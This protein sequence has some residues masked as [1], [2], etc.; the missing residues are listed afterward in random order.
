V[1]AI[2]TGR[3]CKVTDAEKM[4][5]NIRNLIKAV[6]GEKVADRIQILYGGSINEETIQN[7]AKSKKINGF[8]VG[9]ASVDD[10]KFATI[11]KT[12]EANPAPEKPV[13]KVVKQ[14]VKK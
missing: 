1:W 4:I 11:V 5:D 12:V 9:S 2:G 10:K 7:F 3:T 8:L 14:K 13:K 6:Y